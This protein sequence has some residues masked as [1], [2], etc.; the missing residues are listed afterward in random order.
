MTFNKPILIIGAGMSGLSLAQALK[1]HDIPYRIFERDERPDHRSQGWSMSLHF[2]LEPLKQSINPSLYETLPTKASVNPRNHETEFGLVNGQTSELMLLVDSN[3]LRLANYTTY[4]INRARFRQWLLSEINVEWNQRIKCYAADENGVTITMEDGTQVEGSILIG[5]DGVNSVVAKQLIGPK[6]FSSTT[7]VNPVRV[8]AML[9]WVDKETYEVYKHFSSTQFMAFGRLEN[10]ETVAM[11]V[12]VND[13]SEDGERYQML[14]SLSR[15]DP[16]G[17]LPLKDTNEDLLKQAKEWSKGF[18]GALRQLVMDSPPDTIVTD[19]KV[20]ERSP[21]EEIRSNSAK[22]R[23]TLVG[24][25]AHT[26]TMFRGEGGN[27]AILDSML[28]FKQILEVH[29]GKKSLSDA[30]N[31]YLDEMIPRGSKAVF[32]SHQACENTHRSPEMM[33]N[34]MKAL[35][36]RAGVK[37]DDK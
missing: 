21:S 32:E 13:I 37:L 12:T 6:K 2:C 30:L 23:V 26:M 29:Q 11:F 24:D 34:L 15:Y 8:L 9:R 18:E 5:A 28:L 1:Q 10:N 22:G 19:L 25:A 14:Y 4:R 36:E 27:H 20:R 16:Q 3:M 31:A 17:L 35:V 7:T 33:V